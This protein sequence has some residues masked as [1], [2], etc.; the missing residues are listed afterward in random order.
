VSQACSNASAH[1]LTGIT[2]VQSDYWLFFKCST[3]KLFCVC[4][5]G[6]FFFSF[7]FWFLDPRSFVCLRAGVKSVQD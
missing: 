3:L 1:D 5:R 6:F 2:D 7:F 4:V